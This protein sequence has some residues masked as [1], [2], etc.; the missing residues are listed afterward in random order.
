MTRA[1]YLIGGVLLAT[2]YGAAALARV[3]RPVS[4]ELVAFRRREQMQRLR[5][6]LQ[7][8]AGQAR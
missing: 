7:T 1:P 3:K 5:R 8:G 2:G 6:I 4:A